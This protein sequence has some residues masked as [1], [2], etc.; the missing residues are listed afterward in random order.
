MK[1]VFFSDTHSLHTYLSP[2]AIPDGDVL[3]H[4]GDF[5][6]IGDFSDI[7]K[8]RSFLDSLPHPIKL[9]CAGNHDMSF[10]TSYHLARGFLERED[11]GCKGDYKVI[12][13]GREVTNSIYYLQDEA[14]LINGHK[15]YA[16]P[17]TIEFN[18]WAF[19]RKAGQEMA[20]VWDRIPSDVEVLVTH[21]PP[22]GKL[23]TVCKGSEHLGC[24]ELLKKVKE[25]KPKIHCFGHIHGGYG[26]LKNKYTTYVNCSICT[27]KYRPINRPVVLEL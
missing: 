7:I 17:W 27:E 22:Y 3:I 19:M 2:S 14:I 13:Q 9:I 16:S 5:T 18:S 20:A 15:F 8:F 6:N 10:Q 21:S 4:A 26:V 25:I 12:Y 11:A 23:D 24:R 1:L